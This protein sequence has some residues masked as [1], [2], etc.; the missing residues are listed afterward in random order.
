MYVLC[1]YACH[2]HSS[3]PYIQYV[4]CSRPSRYREGFHPY[5][6]G[7]LLKLLRFLQLSQ[8]L[9]LSE[10]R[11]GHLTYLNANVGIWDPCFDTECLHRVPKQGL[12]AWV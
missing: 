8:L 9:L 1:A 6:C 10:V 4:T 12:F 2:T 11:L 5:N 3:T 7:R